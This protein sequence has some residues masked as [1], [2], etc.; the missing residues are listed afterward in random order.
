MFDGPWETCVLV[1]GLSPSEC[2][3]WVQA[4]GSLLA[5]AGAGLGIWWQVRK[6]AQQRAD[7]LIR[8]EADR[9]KAKVAEE[10]RRLS[11]IASVFFQCIVILRRL[12]IA[13]REQM[14]K[15]MSFELQSL[16]RMV[17]FVASIPVLDVPDLY[18]SYAIAEARSIVTTLR[19]GIENA[20]PGGGLMFDT[21]PAKTPHARRTP[22]IN[23]AIDNFLN[24][25]QTLRTSL[26]QRGSDLPV[27]TATLNEQVLHTTR[28]KD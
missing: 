20:T 9:E 24:L 28:S 19:F 22:Y 6:Q 10:V 7:D 2:A 27:Q 11:A 12:E 14:R 25:E 1:R 3:S 13:S 23:V 21:D 16:E 15:E 5:V 26:L 17:D 18:A 4:W 8:I